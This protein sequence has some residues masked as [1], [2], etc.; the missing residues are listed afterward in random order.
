[1]TEEKYM[2]LAIELAQRGCGR[3]NPNPMVGA[4]IVKDGAVI[5]Q[6]WHE[7]YG[8][9]HAERNAIANCSCDPRGAV[10]YVTLEPCC[11]YGKTPPCTQ[12]II[13]SGIKKVVVG[14]F[15][16][17]PLVSGKGIETLQKA[18]V[19]VQTGC[20]TEEC[21]RIN[22]VF[23]HYIKNKIPFV[24]MKYAMTMD[25][26]TATRTGASKWI[27][28]EQSR[29]NVHHS[30]H[31]Y[32][33]IMVGVGTVL[34]DDPMLNCRLE[35]G[36]DPIRIICDTKLKTP[37]NSKVI[38]TAGQI[39]TIIATASND[40]QRCEEYQK[41][42]CKILKVKEK[43]GSV[44]LN[45]L[46]EELGELGIDSILL[47]GGSTLNYSALQ[48]GIVNKIQVYIAPKLFGGANA[49]SPIG[50]LGVQLPEQAFKVKNMK[51]TAIGE[52]FLLEGD[53]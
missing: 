41:T 31:R 42:G 11:H 48:A 17:N 27:S 9:L 52:D 22:E 2:G 19:E 13:E 21:D 1:M 28:G 10:M 43:D 33:G 45:Q 14:S 53:L 15:D 6:G 51:I 46:M 20:M 44:D 4:V 38:N 50:G 49:K 24:V 8:G 26:K 5:G 16:P 30:R 18:G 23:F 35:N 32:M 29:H 36:K 34:A 7:Y 3:V 12:A 40:E 25:G 39:Q 47:E 37:L